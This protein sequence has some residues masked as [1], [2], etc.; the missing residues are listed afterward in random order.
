[1]PKMQDQRIQRERKDFAHRGTEESLKNLP[2]VFNMGFAAIMIGKHRPEV[3]KAGLVWF[4]LK[5]ED[6]DDY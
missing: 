6:V 3:D 5:H 2:L 1:M 4:D